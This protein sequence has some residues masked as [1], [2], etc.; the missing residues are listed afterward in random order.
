MN[1]EVDG[2]EEAPKEE[3]SKEEAKDEVPAEGA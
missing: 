2:N 1:K 3:A